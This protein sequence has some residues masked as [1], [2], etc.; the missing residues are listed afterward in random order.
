MLLKKPNQINTIILSP[1]IQLFLG[2]KTPSL[3]LFLWQINLHVLCNAK[4]IFVK[5]Q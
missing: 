1:Y 2:N 4:V 3:V 5:E